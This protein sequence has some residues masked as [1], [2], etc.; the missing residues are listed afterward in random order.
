MAID[1]VDLPNL[2]ISNADVPSFLGIFLPGTAA[3]A[4]CP[5]GSSASQPLEQNLSTVALHRSPRLSPFTGDGSSAVARCA[6]KM[7]MG[8]YLLIQF[9]GE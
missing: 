4:E 5:F 2:P 6:K 7:G 1:F 3:P 8:Q 9:L